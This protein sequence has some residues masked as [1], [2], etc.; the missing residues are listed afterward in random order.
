MEKNHSMSRRA[1]LKL[2]TIA[3]GALLVNAY[4]LPESIDAKV[5][6]ED[7]SFQPDAYVRIDP[8]NSV[9]VWVSRSEMGQG[10]RTSFPMIVAEELEVPVEKIN[11]VQ[12]D[13]HYSYGN[14]RTGGSD[15]I[16]SKYSGLSDAGAT[17]RETLIMAAAN[18]WKVGP[19]TCRA[20]LGKVIHDSSARSLEY[21]ALVSDAAKLKLVRPK[22]YK[23]PKDYKVIGQWTPHLDSLNRVTGKAEF[24]L[25]VERP[26]MLFASVERSPYLNGRVIQFNEEHVFNFPG[27]RAVVGISERH[28]K[29]GAIAVVADSYWQAHQARQ[30]LKIE[31]ERDDHSQTNSENFWEGFRSVGEQAMQESKKKDDLEGASKKGERHIEATYELPFQ[32]HLT[33]EPMN[34]VADVREDLCEIWAPTQD[35]AKIYTGVARLVRPLRRNQI[36][37]HVTLMGCGLGRRLE[38]DFVKEAVELSKAVKKP[39]KV[40]WTR[41]DDVKND[42]YRTMSLHAMR[43]GVDVSKK[44]LFYEHNVVS[45]RGAGPM[46]G[47]QLRYNIPQISVDRKYGKHPVPT[48]F[49]RSVAYSDNT[50]AVESFIDELAH[51]AEKDPMDFRIDLLPESDSMRTVLELVKE[52]SAWEQPLPA[53]QF[54]GVACQETFGSCTAEVVELSVKKSGQVKIHRVICAVDCGQ[55]INPNGVL[56][57]FESGISLAIP[58]VLGGEVTIK[59][60]QVEQSNYDDYPVVRMEDMPEVEVHT[61]PSDKYSTGIGEP[62]VPPL[63]PAVA[64]AIFVA[65]GKRLRR[66]PIQATDLVV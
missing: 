51:L 21:G 31:W 52:K 18:R 59:N 29:A 10:V 42:P 16:R 38:D 53:G 44:P 23:K 19:E 39:V 43:G 6:T 4:L 64:N 35:P 56:A 37:V 48:G 25:D 61:V 54:R 50:F 15:S 41:E 9:W 58:S 14:M 36:K 49:W 60:G 30:A 40:V 20:E 34:C 57:Q 47:T 22:D 32:P 63:A 11:V 2:G 8:D 3:G 1:F 26:G 27:V 33:M 66:L 12:A 24:G 7:E 62:P 5:A 65:T 13:Y 55:V 17:A 45:T 28:G 46:L